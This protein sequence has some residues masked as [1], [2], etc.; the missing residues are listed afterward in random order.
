MRAK[1]RE[2]ERERERER[3]Q[4]KEALVRLAERHHTT[5]LHH[6]ILALFEWFSSVGTFSRSPK[7]I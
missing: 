4:N 1:A 7:E 2:R 6:R 5:P 3:A